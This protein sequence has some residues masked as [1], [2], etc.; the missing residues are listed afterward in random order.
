[1]RREKEMGE[2]E[3]ECNMV[4]RYV[5]PHFT[6]NLGLYPDSTSLTVVNLPH[7]KKKSLS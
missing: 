5:L 6:Y 1:M 7:H 4:T 2:V 3:K